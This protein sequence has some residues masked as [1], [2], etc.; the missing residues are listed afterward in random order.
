MLTRRPRR[1]LAAAC[2]TW[3]ALSL[4]PA[5]PAAPT[6]NP[7]SLPP[8]GSPAE[9]SNDVPTLIRQL[10]D[11]DFRTREAAT[12]KLR[13]I[14]KSAVPALR[15]ALASNDPEVCSRADSLLRQI[16]RPRIPPGWFR[17]FTDWRRRESVTNGSRVVEVVER[18]RRVRVTEGPAGIEI[19]ISGVDDGQNIQLTITARSADELRRKAPEA[20]DVYER[21]AG[22]RANLNLRGRR[23]IVPAVPGGPVPVPIPGQGL[24]M[25]QAPQV[26]L[27]PLVPAPALRPPADD[28]LDLE[29]RIRRQMRL[30]EVNEADQ[31]AVIDAIR[32][33]RAIQQK[34]AA[35]APADLEAQVRKYNALSDALRQKL[36][37]LKLPGP[38][39]ALPPPARARLGV[40]VAAPGTE[41]AVANGV[42]VTTVSPGSRGEKLGLKPGDVIRK[43][44]GKP[45][46]DAA[47]LRRALT[48]AKDAL[49]LDV[50]RG[51][52]ATVLKEKAP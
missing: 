25:P 18:E 23:L 27:L 50:E 8:P 34:G 15:E 24:P 19:L 46:D 26:R 45:V 51:G 36:E 1:S 37:E 10:G 12:R 31:Q 42:R 6:A 28:L 43:V 40:S 22:A 30:A 41:D 44:N 14:G 13:E 47:S 21:V 4:I 9:V 17:N 3:G 29:V 35:Q 16:E 2:F 7:Q 52:V 49:V 32:M 33:L 20:Y 38:G 5:S 48:D 11:G 39:D